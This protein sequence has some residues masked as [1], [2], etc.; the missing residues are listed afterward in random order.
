MASHVST[1]MECEIQYKWEEISSGEGKLRRKEREKENGEKGKKEKKEREREGEERE[2]ERGRKRSR[3]SDGQNSLDQEVKSGDSTRGYT[4]RGRDSS[5]F[6][7]LPAFRILFTVDFG[8]MLCHVN[9]MGWV[10]SWFKGLLLK[11][12]WVENFHLREFPKCSRN[13]WAC[14]CVDCHN[15][16]AH[17]VLQLRTTISLSFELR[18]ACSWTL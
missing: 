14:Y 17:G 11:R 5:Y 7:L 15:S 8:T 9:G 16:V 1:C 6:G 2:R 12:I 18:F 3:R 4:S 10:Y 13:P